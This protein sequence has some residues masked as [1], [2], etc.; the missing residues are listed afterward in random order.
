MRLKRSFLLLPLAA[1]LA[2]TLVFGSVAASSPGPNVLELGTMAPVVVPFTGSDNPIR[3][4]NG[5]GVPWRIDSA[6]GELSAGGSLEIKVRGLVVVSSG[7]NPSRTFRGIVNC[8]TTDSPMNGVNLVTDAVPATSTGDAD[9]EAHLELPSPCV[10]PI[11]FVTNG[12]AT[13]WFAT[14]GA[15]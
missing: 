6:K 1:V 12:T 2:T 9:I 10:A 3:G 15:P 7:V 13:A 5:G 8:L 11:V 14:T 4:L